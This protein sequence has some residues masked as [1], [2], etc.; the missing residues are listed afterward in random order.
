MTLED[1]VLNNCYV[2]TEK[3]FIEPEK[4][5][6]WPAGYTKPTLTCYITSVHIN[7]IGTTYI[8][9]LNKQ[10]SFYDTIKNNLLCRQSFLY[11]NVFGNKLI[12]NN[13]SIEI[14]E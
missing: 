13:T 6:R 9:R 7:N 3:I 10:T 4:D 14:L 2:F 8:G 12:Y 5:V 1:Y 11:L